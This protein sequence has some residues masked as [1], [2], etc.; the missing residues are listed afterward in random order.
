[1]LRETFCLLKLLANPSK[2]LAF[3]IL[4]IPLKLTPWCSVLAEA[5]R[6]SSF[7]VFNL[8]APII[9]FSVWLAKDPDAMATALHEGSWHS[10]PALQPRVGCSRPGQARR[11]REWGWQALGGTRQRR[12][13]QW[14]VGPVA[15]EMWQYG[16]GWKGH[17]TLLLTSPSCPRPAGIPRAPSPSPHSGK[18]AV[19]GV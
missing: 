8:P 12:M 18:A 16:R 15:A 14:A 1:M 3:L 2:I 7:P 4:L 17:R 6:A 19:I 13:G 5:L 11:A 9:C 10:S